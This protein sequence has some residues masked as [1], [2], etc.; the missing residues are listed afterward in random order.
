MRFTNTHFRY[1]LAAGLVL[2][3]LIGCQ[4][5]PKPTRSPANVPQKSAPTIPMPPAAQATQANPGTYPYPAQGDEG[6]GS[7]PTT[8]YPAAGQTPG[9]EETPV[10]APPEGYPGPETGVPGVDNSARITGTITESAP[11]ESTPGVTRLHVRILTSEDIEG[12]PNR[13][14][15]LVEKETDLFV[16]TNLLNGLKTG[17]SFEAVVTFAGDESSGRFTVIEIK[18]KG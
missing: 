10:A 12:Q 7:Q 5:A 9:G 2:L 18:K 13:T 15:D 14:K 6:Q 4:P 8:G 17:D 16:Q 1:C 11:D 3:A